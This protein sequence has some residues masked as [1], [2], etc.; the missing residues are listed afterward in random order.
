[1][2]EEYDSAYY[3][4]REETARVLASKALDAG[5]RDIHTD[6]ANRY[7]EMAQAAQSRMPVASRGGRRG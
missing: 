7:A 1:M 4:R 3:R 2:I 5:T 6:M